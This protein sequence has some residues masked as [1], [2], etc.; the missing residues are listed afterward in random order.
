MIVTDGST[1]RSAVDPSRRRS[2]AVRSNPADRASGRRADKR[3]AVAVR[4]TDDEVAASPRLCHESLVEGDAR[5]FVLGE[6]RVDGLDLDE[7]GDEPV[8]VVLADRE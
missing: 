8:T 1:R 3:D 6:Q 7:G 4:G 5:G 2:L